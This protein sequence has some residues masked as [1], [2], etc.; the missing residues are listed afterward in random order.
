[1]NYSDGR[2]ICLG[3]TVNLWP[4]TDGK[5]VALLD[6]DKFSESYPESEWQYLAQGI[7]IESPTAGLI[8]FLQPE[9]TMRLVRRC[10]NECE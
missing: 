3:D 4:G 7:L 2:K 8:H 10:E 6:S 5:V 9:L 1:M